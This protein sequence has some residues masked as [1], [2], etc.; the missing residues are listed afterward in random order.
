VPLKRGRRIEAGGTWTEEH[1]RALLSASGL[2]PALLAGTEPRALVHRGHSDDGY[3]LV[4]SYEI[5]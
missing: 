2:L 1:P 4:L 5:G 3:E